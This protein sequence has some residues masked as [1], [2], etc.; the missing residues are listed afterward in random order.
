[1]TQRN[2]SRSDSETPSQAQD[3]QGL[4]RRLFHLLESPDRRTRA[5]RALD[6]VLTATILTAVAATVLGSEPEI[7]AAGRGI[8]AIIEWVAVSIF[9]VEYLTRIWVAAEDARPGD[10][11]WRRRWRFMRS[12]MGLIDLLSVAPT[13]LQPLIGFDLLALRLLRLLRIFK[14]TRMSPALETLAAVL[15]V[16]RRTFIAAFFLLA[17]ISLVAAALMNAIEGAVQPEAF[18]SIPRALWWSVVTATT[19]GYGDVT[20]VT[21]PGRLLAGA[22]AFCGIAL[23]ALPA[24][25]FANSFLREIRRRD[26]I[27]SIRVIAQG[28]VFQT[29]DAVGAAQLAAALDP[30]QYEPGEVVMREGERPDFMY[31]VGSGQIAHSYEGE[32]ELLTRGAFFGERDLMT[33]DARTEG[34]VAQT[35][36]TLLR[37]D[38]DVFRRLCQLLPAF[39]ESMA[40][41]AARHGGDPA[42]FEF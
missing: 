39:R 1:M 33:G 12:P 24:T 19:V 15:M 6:V 4:R 21:A 32:T 38:D 25:I 27:A 23:F 10:G 11:P 2:E 3:A 36:T 28:P 20:P 22:L 8:F 17:A 34:A 30:I 14:L 41:A 18:G 40:R 35:P 31:F 7:K 37:L 16:E 29:L 13:L 26:F 42:R 9:L 5:R